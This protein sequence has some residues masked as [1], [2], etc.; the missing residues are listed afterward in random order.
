MTEAFPF[1]SI[2]TPTFNRRPFYS[3]IIQCF[4]NQTYPADRMEWIIVDDGTDPIGDLVCHI[5]QVRYFREEKK[6]TLG[7]K[8]N[9]MHKESK[10]DF[11]IY[12]DDDDYYPPERVSHAVSML[13]KNPD[14]L[15]AG[16]SEMY[17]YFKHIN[18][19][20][21]FGP[22]GPNHATAATFAF[23]KELLNITSY[24]EESCV[25]EE[26]N[27]LKDYTIPFI[28]LDPVKCILVFSHIHNSCDK[29]TMLNKNDPFI[30]DT[31]KTID[32]FVKEESIKK[33]FLED[34]D[35][36]LEG[37]EPGRPENKEDV[38]KQID[39]LMKKREE[40]MKQQQQHHQIMNVINEQRNTI[41][42]LSKE[43]NFL[44]DKNDYLEKKMRKLIEDQIKQ[45]LDG[46]TKK[47][48]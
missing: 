46:K 45:R 29:K 9:Y 2:C 14:I 38:M 20:Y 36:I 47:S 5:P 40:M 31:T 42:Q 8:R 24:N 16:S 13:Q 3:M 22:Y 37:Y 18:K 1:V 48:N 19:M 15:M 25:A 11:I 21:Q 41:D 10:G 17:L 39:E 30:K 27:F 33:F 4:Q 26:K 7:K 12:F 6:M 32:D 23:R 28:Q 35:T 34:I 44:K 43:N